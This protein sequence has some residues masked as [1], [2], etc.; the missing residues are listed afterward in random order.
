MIEVLIFSLIILV[1]AIIVLITINLRI[2]KIKQI[3]AHKDLLKQ[4]NSA[5]RI[6][7]SE[8]KIAEVSNI[9]KEFLDKRFHLKKSLSYPELEAELLR[10]NKIE[11]ALFCK[12]MGKIFYQEK[13]IN[14]SEVNSLLKKLEL[15]VKKEIPKQKN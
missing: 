3:S 15:F 5:K 2:K 10:K 13:K 14:S 9:T 6:K 4:I 8:E 7:K 11:I 12:S 1:I